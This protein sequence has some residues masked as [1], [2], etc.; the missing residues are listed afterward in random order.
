MENLT[1]RSRDD[2]VLLL[3]SILSSLLKNAN[4]PCMCSR[5]YSWILPQLISSVVSALRNVQLVDRPG[6]CQWEKS[7]AEHV[8]KPVYT[9]L[10]KCVVFD[11]TAQSIFVF[12]N[13]DRI[14]GSA[15]VEIGRDEARNPLWRIVYEI[16][17]ANNLES[18][19]WQYRVPSTVGNLITSA[20]SQL[21]TKEDQLD[22]FSLLKE[23]LEK[24]K[25][26][27]FSG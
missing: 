26:V 1:N 22:S 21:R 13:L 8:L 17:S 12:Q 25:T 19:F 11:C 15:Q 7:F 24:V 16:D 9:V 14:L 3:N 20:L 5:Y 4:A 2:C 27:S 23:F 18:L 10:C 6:R